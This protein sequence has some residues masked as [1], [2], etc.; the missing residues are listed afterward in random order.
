MTF[1]TYGS[2]VQK[3]ASSIFLYS[4]RFLP[5]RIQE[6]FRSLLSDHLFTAGH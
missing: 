4:V 6:F 3:V 5:L 2:A 1:V